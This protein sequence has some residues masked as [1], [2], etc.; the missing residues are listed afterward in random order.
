MKIAEVVQ[1]NAII[2]AERKN[3]Y[4][5][6]QAEAD[7]RLHERD[8]S[9][10]RRLAQKRQEDYGKQLYRDNVM[11]NMIVSEEQRK[12]KIVE[13]REGKQRVMDET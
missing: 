11:Q 5:R 8:L 9:E 7:E 6:K 4:S 13:V 10:Q 3:I 1:A 2:E 12:R